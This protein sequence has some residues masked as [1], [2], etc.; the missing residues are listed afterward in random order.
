MLLGSVAFAVMATMANALT[1]RCDWQIIAL[2]RTMLALVFAALLGY[3]AGVKFVFLRPRTLWVRSI[4]GS[5]SLVCTFYAYSKIPVS[6]LLTLTHMFPVWVALLSWPVLGE[7][8]S[9]GVWVSV[10]IGLVGV[11]L[12]QQ[13][14]L[15]AGNFASL[16]A[17][18]SS[19]FTAIAMLGLHRLQHI[20]VR[21][22][23]VHFSG[24]SLLFAI[25]TIFLF[26]R[27][28]NT[29]DISDSVTMTMLLG[30]G[31]T[32]TIGQLMLTRAFATGIPARVSVVGLSQ[33][34]FGFVLELVFT[35]VAID[36]QKIVGIVLVL[37]PTGWLMASQPH[38]AELAVDEKSV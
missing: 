32:A 15:A 37:V 30:V 27:K 31:L 38:A 23:V 8:P 7:K 12:I 33:V 36:W 29:P 18:A 9:P 10:V 2:A 16:V 35:T 19:L 13:V 3:G 5:I 20:D 26:E 34:V 22:V 17:L 28:G 11:A 24:V 21:A 1:P 6:D 25:G 14:H 4:A